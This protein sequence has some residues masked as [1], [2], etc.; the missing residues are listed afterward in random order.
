MWE[1]LEAKSGEGESKTR[2]AKTPNKGS[3]ITAATTV[4]DN[5]L[6]LQGN[7]RKWC[8]TQASR[9]I[10]TGGVREGVFITT[11]CWPLVQSCPKEC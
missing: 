5:S 9:H 8:R 11:S 6:I 3:I 7:L 2:G 4:G 10:N 1:V